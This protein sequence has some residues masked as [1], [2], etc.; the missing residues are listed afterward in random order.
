MWF[1]EGNEGIINK[2]KERKVYTANLQKLG[3]KCFVHN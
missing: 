1:H 3:I 2:Q